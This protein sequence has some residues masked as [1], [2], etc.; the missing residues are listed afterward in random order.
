MEIQRIS[1]MDNPEKG[2]LFCYQPLYF[3][4]E[5]NGFLLQSTGKFI[6]IKEIGEMRTHVKTCSHFIVLGTM[7]DFVHLPGLKIEGGRKCMDI[8]E[9]VKKEQVLCEIAIGKQR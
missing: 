6:I 3:C 5:L 9:V 8:K 1:K 2:C 7:N 4:Q